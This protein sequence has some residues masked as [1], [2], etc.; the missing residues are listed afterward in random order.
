MGSSFIWRTLRSHETGLSSVG[1]KREY[2]SGCS[3]HV[4]VPRDPA[5][6]RQAVC[7]RRTIS[8]SQE[9][10]SAIDV[11][12]KVLQCQIEFGVTEVLM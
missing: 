11:G 7:G 4:D 6:A 1:E 9:L 8:E 12:G 3:S 2:R 5:G 10:G